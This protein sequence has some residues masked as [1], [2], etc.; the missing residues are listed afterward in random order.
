MLIVN[1]KN[2]EEYIE[3]ITTE[4]INRFNMQLREEEREPS[5]IEKYLRDVNKFAMWL[6]VD[7]L[8]HENGVRYKEKLVADGL[9]PATINGVLSTLNKLFE[10]IRRPDCGSKSCACSDVFFAAKRRNYLRKSIKSWWKPPILPGNNAS[11][12]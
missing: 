12:F 9:K 10:C 3:T 5:T 6:G 1:G 4:M 2:K 8:T 11:G 7:P